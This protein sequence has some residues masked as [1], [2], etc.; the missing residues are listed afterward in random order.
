MTGK[1][2]PAR[3]RLSRRAAAAGPIRRHGG[4]PGQNGRRNVCHD[5]GYGRGLSG[6]GRAG[7]AP[8]CDAKTTT[9]G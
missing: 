5:A 8:R 4:I 7:G 3:L 6:I 9:R 2:T 1:Y